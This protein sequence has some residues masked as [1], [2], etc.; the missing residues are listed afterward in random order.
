MKK[1]IFGLTFVMSLSAVAETTDLRLAK[2]ISCQSNGLGNFYLANL[3]SNPTIVSSTTK[4]IK[5]T[6]KQKN[7]I[8]FSYRDYAGY[9]FK[10]VLD[11]VVTHEDESRHLYKK[12]SGVLVN[13]D[14]ES[15]IECVVE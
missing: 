11:K 15:S 12:L 13:G 6:S 10:I 1:L 9:N 14:I 3:D 5:I 7:S 8:N 2:S 4:F